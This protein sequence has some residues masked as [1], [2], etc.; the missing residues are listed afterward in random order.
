[1]CSCLYVLCVCLYSGCYVH[2]CVFVLLFVTCYLFT[3]PQRP[4]WCVPCSLSCCQRCNVLRL[5][6]IC[7]V[8]TCV[9]CRSPC[10]GRPSPGPPWAGR[11]AAE[12]S[13]PCP[14]LLYY[15]CVYSWYYYY[16]LLLVLLVIIMSIIIIHH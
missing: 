7:A 2:L 3:W 14:Q 9:C 12:L 13:G 10:T 8:L 15:S 1:M 16:V 6:V 5:C 4:S 11:A